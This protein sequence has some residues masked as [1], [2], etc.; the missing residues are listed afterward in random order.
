MPM[1]NK[2][3]LI[4]GS[5]SGI[6]YEF[7]RLFL[8]TG[9][10]LVLVARDGEKLERQKKL[11]QEK[12]CGI[13]TIPLD[14]SE[15]DAAKRLFSLCSAKVPNIDV[16]VNNAGFG[17]FGEH[18]A[19]ADD[20]LREMLSVN[21]VSLTLLCRYFGEQM[22]HRRQGAILNIAST[23]A[24]QPVPGLAAYAATKSFVLNFSEALSKELEDY[25]VTVSCLC[26][27]PTQTNFFYRAGIEDGNPGYFSVKAR[28]SAADVA[29]YG[30]ALLER[31]KIS[32]VPGVRNRALAILSRLS[33]RST[34][35]TVAK[36]LILK[37][38]GGDRPL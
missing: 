36:H 12:S 17:M 30:M 3:V 11:F 28:T 18:V 2:T 21:I 32:G 25:G 10:N 5:T 13:E 9:A 1:T 8:A 15:H 16:L 35:A 37:S 14:L 4:T 22:K 34:V 20:Q 23:G 6:G 33:P 19:L 31:R 7:S 29:K 26:P 24:Y 38:H 27:G